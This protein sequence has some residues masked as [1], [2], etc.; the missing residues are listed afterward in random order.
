MSRARGDIDVKVKFWVECRGEALLGSGRGGLLAAVADHG[1]ISAAARALGLSYATAWHRVDSMNRAAGIPLVARQT[2]GKGGGGAQLTPA[3]EDAL[4]AFH[5]LERRVDE[6]RA[7]A[8]V[9][10]ERVLGRKR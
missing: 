7:S 4:E 8:A 9:E 10:L 3:G 5:L 2:G 6:F 1:S